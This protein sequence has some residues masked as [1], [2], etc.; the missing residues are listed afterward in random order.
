MFCKTSPLKPKK[1]VFIGSL[2]HALC[3]KKKMLFLDNYSFLKNQNS[4]KFL[5]NFLTT[6]F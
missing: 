3:A 6:L 5:S 1:L 4:F 2:S